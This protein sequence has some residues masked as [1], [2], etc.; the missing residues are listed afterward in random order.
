MSVWRYWRDPVASARHQSPPLPDEVGS[1]SIAM[2]VYGSMVD[3]GVC[4]VAGSKPPV[5]A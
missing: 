5:W 2:S 4:E 1:A 3:E